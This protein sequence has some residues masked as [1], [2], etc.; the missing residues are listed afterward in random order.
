MVDKCDVR[1]FGVFSC[2]VDIDL[3][4]SIKRSMG[5]TVMLTAMCFVWQYR[6]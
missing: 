5:L 1:T 3:V 2:S 6:S 4:M